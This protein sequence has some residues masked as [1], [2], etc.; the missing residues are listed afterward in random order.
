MAR[1]GEDGREL[2]G[3]G[4][5]EVVSWFTPDLSLLEKSATILGAEVG[6]ES[7]KIEAIGKVALS[8]FSRGIG[9]Q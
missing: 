4:E 6:V 1:E 3:G 9:C 8:E 2:C 7:G 5:R